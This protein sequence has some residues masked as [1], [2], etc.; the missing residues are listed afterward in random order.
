MK[1][2]MEY[3]EDISPLF[4]RLMALPLLKS[5][6]E[7]LVDGINDDLINYCVNG[8]DTD[9]FT[10]FIELYGQYITD[11]E[12]LSYATFLAVVNDN[13]N[14]LR[15]MFGKYD[16]TQ[17]EKEDHFR[18]VIHHN[19]KKCFAYLH[20]EQGITGGEHCDFYHGYCKHFLKMK[21]EYE[22]ENS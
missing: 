2:T 3:D 6:K 11:K 22:E 15:V 5:F 16:L 12:Q 21:R 17:E 20:G 13:V 10:R 18:T 4:D 14:I 9:E 7:K 8:G 19:S 1:N